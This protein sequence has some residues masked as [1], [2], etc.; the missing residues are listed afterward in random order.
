LR[1]HDLREERGYRGIRGCE[2]DLVKGREIAVQV[3]DY[4]IL[5][6][7]YVLEEVSTV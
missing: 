5:A 6:R 2:D 7:D 3:S 1:S 4:D